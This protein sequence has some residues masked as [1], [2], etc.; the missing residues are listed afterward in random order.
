MLLPAGSRREFKP[1]FPQ[2]RANHFS[3]HS[4]A[5]FLKEIRWLC[6]ST[7]TFLSRLTPSNSDNNNICGLEDRG[8]TWVSVR[9]D[10]VYMDISVY[11]ILKLLK[12]IYL[13]L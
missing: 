8:L 5:R 13:C 2:D 6:G 7:E 3:S 10:L 9:R 1:F 12:F 4:C 11:F